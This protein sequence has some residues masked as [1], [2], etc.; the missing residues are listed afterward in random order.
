MR[1]NDYVEK[2]YDVLESMVMSIDAEIHEHHLIRDVEVVDG[3]LM[4]LLSVS[5]HYQFRKNKH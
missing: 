2:V 3:F 1:D 4:I 5:Q